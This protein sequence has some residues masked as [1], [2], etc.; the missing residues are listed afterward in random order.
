MS[1]H[2]L[3][4]RQRQ[5][6]LRCQV[7]LRHLG[8]QVCLRQNSRARH[9]H[10]RHASRVQQALMARQSLADPRAAPP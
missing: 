3:A 7:C 2:R 8:Y 5:V 9:L 1:G 10:S 4:A 6:A